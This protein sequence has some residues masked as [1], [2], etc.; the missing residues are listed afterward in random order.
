M[1]EKCIRKL[2]D[3]EL[4]KAVG[5]GVVYDPERPVSCDMLN[6]ST[7]QEHADRCEWVTKNGVGRCQDKASGRDSGRDPAFVA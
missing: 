5:G 1:A 6:Q 4:E 3:R 2:S 7:C